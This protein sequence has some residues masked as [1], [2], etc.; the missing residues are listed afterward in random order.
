MA[1]AI[2]ILGS[3]GMLALIA[4]LILS[5]LREIGAVRRETVRLILRSAFVTAA[6]GG[7]YGGFALLVRQVIHADLASGQNALALMGGPYLHGALSALESPNWQYPL[8]GAFS[9]VAHAL[10]QVLFSQYALAGFFL[11]YL[12]TTAAVCLIRKRLEEMKMGETAE[13]AVTLLLS[14]PFGVFFFL[15]CGAPLGLLIAA[16]GFYFLG[17]RLAGRRLSVPYPVYSCALVLSAALSAAVVY[18]MTE[19]VLG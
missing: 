8:T 11:A 7:C 5:F 6:V 4:L 1:D 18:A 9:C 3:V 17:R 10:G 14:L 16:C 13:R 12:M 2:G 19:G 15:P